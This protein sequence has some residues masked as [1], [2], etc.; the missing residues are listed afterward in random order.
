MDLY[1]VGVPSIGEV[2]KDRFT[3]ARNT[4]GLGT[5]VYAFRE[6][7]PASQNINVYSPDRELYV[8]ED[9]LESPIQPTTLDATVALHDL[10]TYMDF[11]AVY[12]DMGMFTFDDALEAG[13]TLRG[14]KPKL[15]GETGFG[16]GK[17]LA[18]LAST[19]LI[20]TPQLRP[21]YGFDSAAL[22]RDFIQATR[23]AVRMAEESLGET[24]VQPVNVLLHPEH[25]GVA[26]LAGAGGNS[27]TWGCVVFKEVVDDIVGRETT[28]F[29]R[30]PGLV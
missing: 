19:I 11:L 10:S 17:R 16:T 29:E 24:A 27:G 3:Y 26:P 12:D 28:S 1:R 20:H 13:D 30:V 21:S 4:G 18:S 23:T 22:L 5:G 9:I 8:L 6:K 2:Y 14:S 25:D 15:F 7:W